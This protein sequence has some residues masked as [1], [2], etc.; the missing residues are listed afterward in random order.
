MHIRACSY[1]VR[2]H[3]LSTATVNMLGFFLLGLCSKTTIFPELLLLTTHINFCSGRDTLLPRT[4]PSWVPLEHCSAVWD[5]S[6]Q[7][8]LIWSISQDLGYHPFP[9]S[10]PIH[11]SCREDIGKCRSLNNKSSH[12][13]PLYFKKPLE[14]GQC[15]LYFI[16]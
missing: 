8:R 7:Q 15:F 5:T 12:Q 3:T 9:P 13:C 11:P 4:A 16:T 2:L 10:H 6:Q 1:L 14:F